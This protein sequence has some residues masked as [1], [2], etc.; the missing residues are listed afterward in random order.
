M[1]HQ[2]DE[3]IWQIIDSHIFYEKL[4]F[5]IGRKGKRVEVTFLEFVPQMMKGSQLETMFFEKTLDVRCN[6]KTDM[7]RVVKRIGD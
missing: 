6:L 3:F 4:E 1:K 2:R 7:T 5:F